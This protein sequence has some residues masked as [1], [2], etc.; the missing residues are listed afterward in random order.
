MDL[1]TSWTWGIILGQS[2]DVLLCPRSCW[3]LLD[4]EQYC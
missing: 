2:W 1:G 3:D 4:V